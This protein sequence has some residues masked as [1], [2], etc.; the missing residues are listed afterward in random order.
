[1]KPWASLPV[2][3]TEQHTGVL[4]NSNVWVLHTAATDWGLLHGSCMSH[5]AGLW[6]KDPGS[7]GW[8]PCLL[9]VSLHISSHGRT[10][11]SNVHPSWR[12]SL[13]FH[14]QATGLVSS[15]IIFFWGITNGSTKYSTI[16]GPNQHGGARWESSHFW[17]RGRRIQ[18]TKS[19]FDY[20]VW[21]QCG[22]QKKKQKQNK[23]T[24]PP[25]QPT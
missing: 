10:L 16:L 14:P 24:K 11:S 19:G 20:V 17:V 1:M 21:C 8:P 25:N 15:G 2:Q 23:T 18:N 9:L 22:P 3:R 7:E 13:H 12:H 5:P 4:W 6:R